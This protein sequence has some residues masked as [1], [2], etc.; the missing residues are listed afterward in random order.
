MKNLVAIAALLILA[1]TLRP[2]NLSANPFANNLGKVINKKE[3]PKTIDLAFKGY[4]IMENQRF[5]II[6]MNNQQHT[7]KIGEFLGKIKII[8][9]S[10]DALYYQIGSH[11]YRAPINGDKP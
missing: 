5:A 10:V 3:D 7:L 4:A 6:Q 11:V 9:F 8:R 1:V 2:V